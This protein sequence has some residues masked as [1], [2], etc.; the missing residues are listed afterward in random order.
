MTRIP[1]LA[2]IG[3]TAAMLSGCVVYDPYYPGY[4][5]PPAPAY[6]P[7]PRPA[8]QP[9]ATFDRAWAAALGALNETG[10]GVSAADPATGVIRGATGRTDV[11]VTVARQANGNIQTDIEATGPG[12]R[13]QGLAGRV[14]EAY[15]RRMGL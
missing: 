2:V 13:D 5:Y 14:S 6:Y 12:G 8:P 11:I 3:A 10:V 15:Q 1:A 7:V 4:Y 9:A